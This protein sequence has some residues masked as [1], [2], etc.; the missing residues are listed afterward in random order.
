MEIGQLAR[1][2]A[3]AISKTVVETHRGLIGVKSSERGMRFTIDLP[4]E[5]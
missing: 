2:S 1:A 5:T 3:L 4:L